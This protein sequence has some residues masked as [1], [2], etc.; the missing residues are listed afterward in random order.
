[1]KK[2]NI[3]ETVKVKLNEV[4]LAIYADRAKETNKRFEE[5]NV[6]CKCPIYPKKDDKGYVEFQL[7]DLMNLYGKHLELTLI[8]PFED[9]VIYFDDKVLAESEEENGIRSNRT[10]RKFEV[11]MNRFEK[12]TESIGTLAAF[13]EE[14][15]NMCEISKP[16]SECSIGEWCKCSTAKDF[17]KWLGEEIDA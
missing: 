1:M 16:C 7:W 5:N 14:R 8:P 4:G 12:I 2:I 13:F 15:F 17:E 3:N 11:R 10:I 9:N 6:K